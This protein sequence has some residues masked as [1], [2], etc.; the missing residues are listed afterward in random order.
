[1]TQIMEAPVLGKNQQTG[2]T[3]LKFSHFPIVPKDVN[4]IC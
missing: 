1:M 4:R 2:F 3:V